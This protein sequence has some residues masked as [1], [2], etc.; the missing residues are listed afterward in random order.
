MFDFAALDVA[1]GLI[2]VY[3]VLALVCSALNE[4]IS[5][6]FSWRASFLREVSR[7]CSTPRTT[8]T[9]RSC[10][11]AL[12]PSGPECADPSR[13]AQGE[14]ALPAYLRRGRSPPPCSTSTAPERNAPSRTRSTRFRARRRARR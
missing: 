2:F 4:T 12:L 6:I 7:T 9:G 14:A 3:L 10:D 11:E 13:L 8:A 1:L 5:S